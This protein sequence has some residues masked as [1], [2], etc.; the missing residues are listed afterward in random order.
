MAVAAPSQSIDNSIIYGQSESV[1][2]IEYEAVRKN[3]RK[4]AEA[5]SQ[6]KIAAALFEN[7]IIDS[8]LLHLSLT[9]T[10][11]GE[12]RMKKILEG[13]KFEPKKHFQSLCKA[14][15]VEPVVH[16]VL[17]ELKRSQL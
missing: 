10:E 17:T 7:G 15:E 6:G 12:R 11:I 13:L 9:P 2:S 5:V 3:Y 16:H 14:L 1:E 8:D 4:L